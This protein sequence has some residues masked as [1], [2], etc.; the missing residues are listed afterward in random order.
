MAKVALCL[1]T[2][3]LMS[4]SIGKSLGYHTDSILALERAMFGDKWMHF[5]LSI[6]LSLMLLVVLHQLGRKAYSDALYALL[7]L[8]LILGLDE[9]SQF[10]IGSRHF[11]WRDTLSGVAGVMAGALVFFF[12]Q[13]LL[14]LS[15]IMRRH[16]LIIGSIGKR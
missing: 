3:F 7:F 9:L 15:C 13:V 2:I 6:P 12:W 5:I 10:W 11:D 4:L 14:R 1:Y 16:G 8:V